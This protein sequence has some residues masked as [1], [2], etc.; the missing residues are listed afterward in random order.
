MPSI[1]CEPPALRLAG[2]WLLAG[3][4]AALAVLTAASPGFVVGSPLSTGLLGMLPL[5]ALSLAGL[6][7]RLGSRCLHMA[8]FM[9]V[10]GGLGLL[11]GARL[12]FGAPGLVALA[13]WCRVSPPLGVEG[14]RTVLAIAPWTYG[15]ML[16]G[17]NLGMGLSLLFWPGV[18]VRP[19]VPRYLACNAGMVVGMFLAEGA[20]IWTLAGG[21]GAGPG[22]MFWRMVLGMTAGMWAGWRCADGVG[23]LLGRSSP[24]P[25]PAMAET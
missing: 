21:T 4:A 15:A 13:D 17:C 25:S 3:A 14:I 10:T 9:A 5:L 18:P 24:G 16:I 20:A 11:L 1:P 19:S 12:D 23:R 8:V 2:A 22:G 6:A 7:R